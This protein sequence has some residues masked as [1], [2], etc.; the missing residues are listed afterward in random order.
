M[1][2]NN[3][4]IRKFDFSMHLKKAEAN[5]RKNKF[6]KT[7]IYFNFKNKNKKYNRKKLKKKKTLKKIK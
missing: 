5:S 3:S 6:Q 2:K 7:N 1:L 4:K